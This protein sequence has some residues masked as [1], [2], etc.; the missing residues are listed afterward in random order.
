MLRCLRSWLVLVTIVA[1]VQ[2]QAAITGVVMSRDGVAISGAHVSVSAIETSEVRRVRYLSAEPRRPELAS[3]ETD[4]KGAFKLESPKDATLDLV[5]TANGYAPVLQ[6]IERDQD[7]GAIALRPAPMKSGTITAGGKPVAGATVVGVYA[8]SEYVAKTDDAGRYSVPDP[9]QWATRMIV[10]HPDWALLDEQNRSDGFGRTMDRTL[11]RGVSISGRVVN[12]DGSA[13]VSGAKLLVDDW[14]AGESGENGAFTIA[15]A[16]AAWKVIE[17]RSGSLRGT[18]AATTKG[19]VAVRLGP[20]GILMGV[21]RDAKTQQPIT[22]AVVSVGVQQ[23]GEA[24][25]AITDAKGVYSVVVRP[26]TYDVVASHP[27]FAQRNESAGAIAGKTIDKSLSLT[28]LAR[29]SGSVAFDDK[30]PAVAAVIGEEDASDQRFGVPPSIRYDRTAYAGPDGRFS[31]AVSVDKDIQLSA[32]KKG[33]PEARSSQMKLAASDRKTGVSIT[34]ARGNLVTGKVMDSNQRPLAGV[35]VVSTENSDEGPGRRMVM[36]LGGRSDEMN[37]ETAA[38][39]TFT[40]RLKEGSYDLSFK[41]EGF[42]PK[43]VRSY[44]VA[45]DN[46]PVEVTLE[47]GVEVVGRITRG[48]MGVEGVRIAAMSQISAD[49]NTTSDASGYF[50]ISDLAPG[51]YMLSVIKFEDGIRDN[52]P[53]TAPARDLNIELP[54]GGRISGRVVEKGTRKPI[55]TFQAGTSMSRGG[56]GFMF[57]APNAMR[58]F[59]SDDGSFVLENVAPGPTEVIVRAPGYV[60]GRAPGLNVEDGK[61]LADIE[62]ELDTGARV[63]GKVTDASGS[64]VADARVSILSGMRGPGGM[65]GQMMEPGASSATTDSRGEFV[66][67]AVEPGSV[68]LMVSHPQ[69]VSAEKTIEVT[70][71]EARADFRLDSGVRVTGVVVTEGGVPVADANVTAQ[72]AAGGG[73]YKNARTDANG[74]FSFDSTPAGR[75]TFSATRTGYSNAVVRDVDIS[76]GAPV[77]ITMSSGATITGRISGLSESELAV[78][79][80]QAFS[81]SGRA[82]ATPDASGNF[83]INGAPVGNVQVQAMSGGFTGGRTTAPKYVQVEAGGAAQVDLEFRGDTVIRGRVT[84]NGSAQAGSRILFIPDGGTAQTNANATTDESGHYSVSGLESGRYSVNVIDMQRLSPYSTKY[85]VSGSATFD[86]EIPATQ[87]RGRVVDASTGEPLT[88]ARVELRPSESGNRFMMAQTASTNGSGAFTFDSV[89]EGSYRVVAEKTGYAS[90]SADAQV[91]TSSSD[92]ELKLEKSDGLRLR[93][94]DG[95]DGRGISGSVYV[96]NLQDQF[97][98]EDSIRSDGAEAQKVALPAG[99]YVVRAWAN[100]Y[101]P[102][103][104]TTSSPGVI[105]MPLTPGGT[106]SITSSSASAR[107]ARLVDSSGRVYYLF[108]R[109]RSFTI[110]P[111]PAS[112]DLRSIAPGTYSLQ[113]LDPTGNASDS[114]QVT[115]VEGQTARVSF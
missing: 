37:V 1:G 85:E 7:V 11:S 69:Y 99:Q 71:K 21:I 17:A 38:D 103:T 56:G 6:R 42:A 40:I 27:A 57:L 63:A 16:P 34:M 39:G 32:R 3:V 10:V 109:R 82:S 67:D 55:P 41:R 20:A 23:R 62:V 13:G 9:K 86:I 18:R 51:Q 75:Y 110:D 90:N 87:L 46:K 35:K 50:T 97:V 88:D 15:H 61:T 115:V 102:R 45:R 52:R 65:R 64:A 36:I 80:V 76:A 2:S 30:T 60:R 14:S 68:N 92:V 73:S 44:T 101:A 104:M 70:G 12:A 58:D 114:K 81:S 84:R 83:R 77:R 19:D 47:P 43:I 113:V 72:S 105:S 33:F 24:A 66:L 48:G 22:G 8:S 98:L 106:I 5:V 100:G 94:V 107:E 54:Q 25:G 112:T 111:S 53:V 78:A 59:T 29:V 31:I 4:A 89:A 91:G 74:S 108:G 95:R 49:A 26:G 79:E 96:T 93:L 28:H